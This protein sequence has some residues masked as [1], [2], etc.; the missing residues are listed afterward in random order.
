M[1]YVHDVG[2]VPSTGQTALA[3]AIRAVLPYY[4]RRVSAD[5]R[6]FL[7]GR[8]IEPA[9]TLQGVFH[10]ERVYDLYFIDGWGIDAKGFNGCNGSVMEFATC[11]RDD[12]RLEP[13]EI[14]TEKEESQ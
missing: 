6:E 13:A 14:P 11:M 3:Q 5:H 1:P 4:R 12:A 10:R 9:C 7:I 8:V 2:Y